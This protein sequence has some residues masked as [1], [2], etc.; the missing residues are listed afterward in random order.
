MKVYIYWGEESWNNVTLTFITN[1][2][3]RHR[4]QAVRTALKI[5]CLECHTQVWEEVNGLQN[6]IFCCIG[7]H[8][9]DMNR[10]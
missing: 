2:A 5:N 1:S 8:C 3:E 7:N 10:F 6:G 4:R 9:S